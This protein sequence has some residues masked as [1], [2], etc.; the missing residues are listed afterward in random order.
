MEYFGLQFGVINKIFHNFFY[1][2]KNLWFLFLLSELT[3]P[4][5]QTLLPAHELNRDNNNRI[6][7]LMWTGMESPGA[8]SPT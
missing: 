1:N 7:M 2:S 4:Q 5:M 6:D 3:L 8:L